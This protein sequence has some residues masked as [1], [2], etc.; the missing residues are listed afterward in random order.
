MG[1]K[2][3]VC[4]HSD[5]GVPIKVSTSLNNAPRCVVRKS[6]FYPPIELHGHRG[7][8]WREIKCV[9]LVTDY[10]QGHTAKI[11]ATIAPSGAFVWSSD[12]FPGRVFDIEMCECSGFMDL[13]EEGDCYPADK[14]FD[15]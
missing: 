4:A 10:K 6:V 3:N 2:F 12:A 14:G 13:V 11:L 7:G 9:P 15:G 8:V 5:W 1:R